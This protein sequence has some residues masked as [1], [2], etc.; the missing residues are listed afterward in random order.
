VELAAAIDRRRMVRSFSGQPV[1]DQ[2]LDRLLAGAL[3]APSAGNTGGWSMVVLRGQEE[4]SRFWDATTTESWRS[5]SRRWPGL[6]RAPVIIVL[7]ADPAAYVR[8]YAEADKASSGLGDVEAWPVPYW[9]LDAGACVMTLLLSAVEAGL[10]ACFLGNFR[11][12]DALLERL[13]APAS[14]RYVGAVLIGHAAEADPASA[15]LARGP[16]RVEDV[17]HW[18]RWESTPPPTQGDAPPV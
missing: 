9:F 14:L 17:V 16:R 10:G 12:E 18:G 5:Q 13:G 2:V 11:G 3:R 15:S 6:S 8:R 7:L 1:D 4:T